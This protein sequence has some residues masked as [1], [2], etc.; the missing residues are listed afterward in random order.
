MKTS[1]TTHR[2]ESKRQILS[3]VF[4]GALVALLTACASASQA[5]P[6]DLLKP[7]VPRLDNTVPKSA[8]MLK[9]GVQRLENNK[10]SPSKPLTGNT[11][12]ASTGTSK[13]KLFSGRAKADK[14]KTMRAQLQNN[15]P[16]N[17]NV[18]SGIGIIGVKFVLAFGR[19]P[20]INRVFP[21]TPAFIEGL[22]N[23][24]VIVA[25]DGV[26]T[27]GLSK[28]DVYR[29]IVG[30]PGTPVTVSVSRNGD[31]VAK[32]MN[33]MDFNDITDPMVRHDYLLNM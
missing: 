5:E 19:P 33:R 22:R 4:A 23:N 8:T 21:G 13:F 24:D 9:G 31:F 20:V 11:N 25:V 6:E 27:F 17:A 32:T 15:S 16:L 2:V 26:P 14:Q 7:D 10:P 30:A 28:E 1:N 3:R 12:S 29:M 18:Q